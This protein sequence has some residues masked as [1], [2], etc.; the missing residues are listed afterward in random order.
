MDNL[1]PVHEGHRNLIDF[2][3]V[4]ELLVHS[5]TITDCPSM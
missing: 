3:F 2:T 5:T 4:V 1:S